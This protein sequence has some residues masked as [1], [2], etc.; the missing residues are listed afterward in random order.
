MLKLFC[1]MF[2]KDKSCFNLVLNCCCFLSFYFLGRS[3]Y[4]SRRIMLSVDRNIV[5]DNITSFVSALHM[6]FGSY[7]C[8]NIH[9]PSELAATLEFLQRCVF[10]DSLYPIFY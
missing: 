4:S 3:C 7:Y 5:N 9:Y 2:Q 1:E 8:F 10:L 6:M